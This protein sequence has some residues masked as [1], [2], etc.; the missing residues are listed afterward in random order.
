MTCIIIAGGRV[1]VPQ[2]IVETVVAR[3]SRGWRKGTVTLHGAAKGTDSMA[4]NWLTKQGFAVQAMA[5]NNLL[6]GV[7]E[8]AP[9]RRNARMLAEGLIR[10][11]E[12]VLAFPGGPGTRH[13]VK[14][15]E[16]QNVAIYDVEIEGPLY[17]VWRWSK[18]EKASLLLEGT[19]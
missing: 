19:V 13:M 1:A 8:D 5:I 3:L 18:N 6:D 7:M 4:G 9:K 16:D 17:R 14:I 2:R 15:A 10:G 12:Y 11:L